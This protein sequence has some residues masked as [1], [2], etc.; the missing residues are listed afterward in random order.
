MFF[1][2]SIVIKFK[3]DNERTI[4]IVGANEYN[5]KLR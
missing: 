5:K 3:Y 2:F 1:F 4:E